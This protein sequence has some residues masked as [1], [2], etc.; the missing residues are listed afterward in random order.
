MVRSSDSDHVKFGSRTSMLLKKSFSTKIYPNRDEPHR[1]LRRLFAPSFTVGFV[2]GLDSIFGESI[3]E[4]LEKYDDSAHS[5]ATEK[6]SGFP[7]NL[8]DDSHRVA[9]DIMGRCSFGH[10]FGQVTAKEDPDVGLNQD[11]WKSI[12]L[13][14][15]SSLEQ[16]YWTVYVKRGLRWL[17]FDYKFDWP[18]QMVQVIG[19]II[20][21]RRGDPTDSPRDILQQIIMHGKIPETGM[22]MQTRN[23]IDQMSELLMAG[24]ETTSGTVAA[25]FYE[26]TR[27]PEVKRKLLS[28][29]PVSGPYDPIVDGKVIRN[30]PQYEYLNACIKEILRIHP[31]AS[32]VGRQTGEEWVHLAGYDLPPRTVVSASYRAL[33]LNEDYWPQAQRFWPERWLP[34]DRREGA[35]APDLD[36]FFPFSAGKHSCIGKNFAWAEL[37]MLAGNLLSRFDIEAVPGQKVEFR[38]FITMQ[39]SEGSWNVNMTPRWVS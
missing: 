29:L 3:R 34:E 1:R 23:I 10:G 14:I 38:Q 26:L 11:V 7:T 4:L 31:I 21:Q 33:Q 13:A 12:P 16:R 32:E 19:T 15:F 8:V 39:F 24:S 9:L 27:Y 2:D 30:D 35:P 17:G 36:A 22:Y 18:R 20:D 37:R 28:T 5:Q 6:A 25:L